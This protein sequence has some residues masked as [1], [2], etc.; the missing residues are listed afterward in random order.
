[1]TLNTDFP[2]YYMSARLAH[3][4]FDTSRMYEWPWIEREKDHRG[5]DIRVIGL[6]PITPFSTLAVWPLVWLPPLTAKHLWILFNLALLIP[7]GCMLR[8]IAGLSYQRVALI[9]ALSFPLQR[10]LLFGQ[11]YIV[12]LFLIVAACWS[13]LRGHR[14]RAGAL[15]ALAAACKVFPVLLLLFILQRRD[16]RALVAGIV[17]GL[18]AVVASISVFG[19]AAH[20]TWLEEILPWV[21][22]GEGLQPYAPAASITGVLHCLLLSEPQWNPHP[23]QDSPLAYALLAPASQMLLLAPAILMIRKRAASRQRILLEWSALLTAALTISTIPASYNFVLIAL[24]ICVLAAV[25]IEKKQRGSLIALAAIYLGIGFP[26]PSP[27][28]PP[29]PL[30]LL[31]EPRLPLMLILLAW[32]YFRMWRDRPAGLDARDWSR[33]AW[34]AAMLASV[35]LGTR[36]TLH[37]ERDE[38]LEYAYRLPVAAQGFANAQPQSFRGGVLYSAF[39]F[40]GYRLVA[41]KGSGRSSPSFGDASYDYLSFTGLG[42]QVLA[43][44]A[45]VAGSQIVDPHDPLH[46]LVQNAR[47]PMYSKDANTLAYIQDERGRGRLLSRSVATADSGAGRALSPEGYNVFEASFLS[48]T[49]YAFSAVQGSEE[50]R[51]YLEE[52]SRLHSPVRLSDARYPALSPD[53]RWLAYSHL[54]QG[55]W[56][57]WLLNRDTGQR[58]RIADVPCNQIEPSWEPDVK[59]L[60]YGTDCGRSIWFTAVARR[61]VIP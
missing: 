53:G 43:E 32:I 12:L 46:S 58:R 56:N 4:G 27:H 33:Y 57:L 7:I 29:G 34:A 40:D 19:L 36:S 59:T 17:T 39:S 16:W 1:M 23:W 11:F 6:L 26:M 10:N 30:W 41:Q 61:Q 42:R 54:E 28:G 52:T 38:R 8:S 44:K 51:I 5:V 2:N 24:P 47:D 45:S 20:R 15:I 55:Y 13:Y 37:R 21:M 3:E 49:E 60:L 14:A 50:P 35:V 48:P 9:L 25:M 22:H 18:A 31:Y